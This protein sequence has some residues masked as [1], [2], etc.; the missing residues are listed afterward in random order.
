MTT[1]SQIFENDDREIIRDQG[2][3][4][5]SR[6]SKHLG[7]EFP[8]IVSHSESLLWGNGSCSDS[9]LLPPALSRKLCQLSSPGNTQSEMAS[10]SNLSNFF[11][12]QNKSPRPH[13]SSTTG[14]HIPLPCTSWRVRC[15][16]VG[17]L[18]IATI[19]RRICG[20]FKRPLRWDLTRES[21]LAGKEMK[22]TI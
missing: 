17:C 22:A 16:R 8:G 6:P 2:Y 1:G 13:I 14:S 12:G 18:S 9:T 21:S 5:L 20:N 4:N 19:P 3:V 7:K 15:T 10:L 11:S